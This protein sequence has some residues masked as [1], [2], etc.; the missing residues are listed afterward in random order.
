M[1]D[2]SK[3]IIER[4]RKMIE[5]EKVKQRHLEQQIFDYPLAGCVPAAPA[6]VSPNGASLP[7]TNSLNTRVMPEK[8]PGVRGLAPVT[9]PF[10]H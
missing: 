7:P 10:A 5:L 6:S 2:I 4:D 1:D 3:H 9:T 8:I